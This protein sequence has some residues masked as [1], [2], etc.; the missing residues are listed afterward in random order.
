MNFGNYPSELPARC[1]CASSLDSALFFDLDFDFSGEVAHHSVAASSSYSELLPLCN[2]EFAK[3]SS[4]AEL[5]PPEIQSW[6]STL[7][8]DLSRTVS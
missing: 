1:I 2:T 8:S 5:F 3:H 4:L 6:E 7:K